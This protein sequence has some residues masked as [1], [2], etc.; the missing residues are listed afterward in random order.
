M[1][2]A[3]ESLREQLHAWRD[4]LI[5]LTRRNKLLNLRPGKA[6]VEILQPSSDE[7][8]NGL[9]RC[10]RFHYPPLQ[11]EEA[12]DAALT[13]ALQVE[14]PDLSDVVD[15][16]ELLTTID[17]ARELSNRLR[18]L[19]R[20][21]SGEWID[22][23]VR[24]LYLGVGL[25]EWSDS[26]DQTLLAPL[27]LVPVRLY[28]NSPREPYQLTST[29]DDWVVNPALAVKLNMEFGIELPEL[30]DE[31][32]VSDL[33]AQIRSAVSSQRSWTVTD[34][35]VL[36]TFSFQK[37]AMY[38]DLKD[39][40]SQILEHPLVQA[41]GHGDQP[42]GDLAFDPIDEDQLDEVAPPEQL[43]S[44]L[45]ADATQRAC[46][47]A[48]RDGR[49][50]VMD[51]PPGTGKSQ[52]IAN[53]I[54]E[55][56]HAGQTVLFVSEK[57]AALDVV[58]D[59]LQSAGLHHFVLALHSA[60]ATRK[61]MAKALG[62]ALESRP[63]ASAELTT[64]ELAELHTA[65]RQL[66]DYAAALNEVRQP[67][68]L[69][70]SAA[71]GRR[72][73]LEGAPRAPINDSVARELTEASFAQVLLA[74]QR[75]SRNW[76]PVSR[77]DD[78]LWRDLIDPDVARGRIAGL[79]AE[80]TQLLDLH[81]TLTEIAVQLYTEM[82]RPPRTDF[83]GFEWL[84]HL[85]NLLESP[86]P[87]QL[88]WVTTAG[89]DE[90]APLLA[91]RRNAAER[92]EAE[93]ASL[94]AIA[95]GWATAPTGLSGT[96][97]TTTSTL[98]QLT[99]AIT[100]DDDLP[101]NAPA[102]QAED[103]RTIAGTAEE[104]QR[105]AE[106]IAAMFG[107]PRDGSLRGVATLAELAMLAN[108]PNK[109]EAA[110]LDPTS[111]ARARD[112]AQILQP[113]I[114]DYRSMTAELQRIFTDGIFSLDIEALYGDEH[115]VE[116]NLSRVS[117]EGRRNRRQLKACIQGGKVTDEA[118]AALPTARRWQRL[119]ATITQ[120][121]AE[122]AQSLGEYYYRRVETDFQALND[123]L[124]TAE[125]A[126]VLAAGADSSHLAA[127]VARNALDTAGLHQRGTE[128]A[129]LVDRLRAHA[130]ATSDTAALLEQSDLMAVRSW[131]D[132]AAAALADLDA[133]LEAAREL[134]GPAAT[135]GDVVDLV[136]RRDLYS[137]LEHAFTSTLD[138]D[139]SKL[140]D[141]FVGEDT[142]WGQLGE[143]LDWVSS[144]RS[145]F[146]GALSEADAL[147]LDRI[148]PD[149][150]P[151]PDHV[152]RLDKGLNTLCG[153]FGEGPSI[154]LRQ[155]LEGDARDVQELLTS[156]RDTLNDVDIWSNYVA[157]TEGLTTDG[158]H[159]TVQFCVDERLPAHLVAATIER[160]VLSSW[161]D[162]QL[163]TDP[164][165]RP[166]RSVERDHLVEEFR[167]LDARLS[168]HAAARAINACSERRPTTAAGESAIIRSE[169]QKKSRHRPIRTLLNDA[170]TV[171]RTLTPCFMMSPLS[172]SQYLSADFNFDVVIFDEASQVRPSDAINCIY[173][174]RRLIVAGDEKQLPPT[175]F[176]DASTTSDSDEYDEDALE[177]FESVLALCRRS[178]SLRPLPL[179][180]HY[181]SRHEALI[182]FSNHH[183]YNGE[184][185]SYPGALED[186][187]EL[188]VEF[189][190]V[191]DGVYTRGTARDNPVEAREVVQRVLF[192]AEHHSE[193]TLG[194]VAFSEAQATR[195][196]REIE[197]ARRD[198][199]DLDTYFAEDRLDGFFIKNIENV[200][201]DER[202]I[203]IF[204]VGYGPD[205]VGKFLL[206]MGALNK[207]GGERR[208]NVAVTRARR[209]VEVVASITASDLPE[210]TGS[211]GVKALRAY[212]RYAA[213]GPDALLPEPGQ[214]DGEV[215]SPFEGEVRKVIEGW[216]Y[217][218]RSQVGHAG[219]RIDLGVLHPDRDG[220]YALAVE[221]DGAAYHSSKVAR[222]RDRLRQEV[223]EGL[224]WQ[225]FRV[226]GPAWYRDRAHEESRL[227]GA[228]ER[229]VAG[230]NLRTIDD[231]PRRPEPEVEVHAVDLDDLPEWVS[232]YQP[233]DKYLTF[234]HEVT[235][236]RARDEMREL[237]VDIVRHEGPITIELCIRRVCEMWGVQRR[238]RA[239]AAVESVIK[240]LL[241]EGRT[242]VE[243]EPGVLHAGEAPGQVRGSTD[244]A[245]VR[246][247]G[248]V[249]QFELRLAIARLVEDAKSISTSELQT[250]VARVFGWKRTGPDITA[251]LNQAIIEAARLDQI[252]VANDG[253]VRLPGGVGDA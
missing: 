196:E 175:A 88:T 78:F 180:W 142:D 34:R 31:M 76:D 125:R 25:L 41:I 38:Q 39:N 164:R 104:L 190:H 21:A 87:L 204:S 181:R 249:P 15:P 165:C 24:V 62:E 114:D 98:S 172:V 7:V 66:N 119:A 201:G 203:I 233:Y 242:V 103:L 33:M 205:E 202:D 113:L 156:L 176:F 72:A 95:T 105:S 168:R 198:R 231:N 223:L 49:S 252:S 5:D 44:I 22:K 178:A 225:V 74:A 213:E 67:L 11:P 118:L 166:L 117:S 80:L 17:S 182:T 46:I 110:W 188:G 92:L 246:Q 135:V 61:E 116:V 148:Q 106:D 179:R 206:N 82:G 137:E 162:E 243:L 36:S 250:R 130:S 161:I 73:Q 50:F 102:A 84:T 174:G 56:M 195:I 1:S 147:A 217:V 97:A 30:V 68:N 69:T 155:E 151:I 42:V 218:V 207:T 35:L 23:G 212:L 253:M 241:A 145:L 200:Q 120:T 234:R 59:R 123:A 83:E 197:L 140:G 141:S 48:A 149:Q 91:Q 9:D 18:S 89:F 112:A 108:S 209:R 158:L 6:V 20:R 86:P 99:P 40:E 127:R 159:T 81:A 229:V 185:I 57:A 189:F 60:K 27:L 144:L 152:S 14:D 133:Q 51:G 136:R 219:Y 12:Q 63:R 208:L 77:G 211:A 28:R 216:G 146:G 138:A 191:P 169:A 52:T 126:L 115:S 79:E 96:I 131:A 193:R 157:T 70:L 177:E 184:L 232:E 171:V 210:S 221:C 226:W 160:A 222:D 227:K 29:D 16:D 107:V 43:A 85:L 90:L 194:V 19:E 245:A 64:T 154:T 53:V 71:I 143:G 47:V 10:W 239:V 220:E 4:E 32:W 237:I 129:A 183:F 94:D 8:L 251:A 186:S 109:P 170:G 199:P 13:A 153:L 55:L 101:A 122:R 235:D 244:G 3:V 93:R 224:G 2:A 124:D 230:K 26:D 236:V 37:N 240:A 163:A 134:L 238:S 45:D 139:R 192:H 111:L 247:V 132:A 58:Y 248:D 100:L 214:T 65:R 167:R 173:R 54:A 128:L 150:W 215:E 75:L 187:P 228:I 121:E